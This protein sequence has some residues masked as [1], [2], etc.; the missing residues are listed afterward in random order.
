[1]GGMR[2]PW[3]SLTVLGLC[4]LAAA[5]GA[6]P[7][8]EGPAG[9]SEETGIGAAVLEKVLG[10]MVRMRSEMEPHKEEELE[11]AAAVAEDGGERAAPA[12]SGN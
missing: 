8:A 9:M 1:M 2:M 3:V 4:G 11:P 6:V 12:E 10:Q 5:A 7:E